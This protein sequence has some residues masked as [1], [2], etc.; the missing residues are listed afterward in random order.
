MQ[1][2]VDMKP[3]FL[4]F[5]GGNYLEGDTID[6]RFDWKKT[7]GPITSRPG[8]Q[9]PW[10]YMSTDGLGLLEFLE[11]T[12]DM[13]AQSVL[14][15]YAGYSLK[16]AHV[17]PGPDLVPFIQDDLDE[18]EYVTGDKS[19]KW[20]DQRIADGHPEPFPLHYVEIG[21]EDWFDKSGSYDARFAQIADAIHEKYP[22]LKL[23]ATTKVKSDK[24]DLID[25]H[26]YRN[27]GQMYDDATHYDKY[28]RD[29]Q[30]VFVGE[31]ATREGAPTTNLNAALGD[32]AWMTGMERNSD[33][34]LIS[35]Y[36]P[37]FVNVNKGG[38]QWPS[39]LIGYDALNSFG[40][41]SY[42][43]QKIFSEN[44]GDT[45]VSIEGADIPSHSWQPAG[46]RGSTTKPPAKDVPSLF[47]VATRNTQT[48]MVYLK[49][50][51][52]VDTAQNVS[53]TLDGAKSVRRDGHAN[54]H[55]FGQFERYE[56]HHGAD[57]DCARVLRT[58]WSCP[59]LRPHLPPVLGDNPANPHA[60]K[61]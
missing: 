37:L 45:I 27:S 14:A 6:Q 43:V 51:N 57:E 28:K 3:S 59:V 8:H 25:E 58:D 36:A 7:V 20:G 56:F 23:I 2:L 10:K 46:R 1:K 53:I 44:L 41:P 60:V 30:K 52:S 47:Y 33:V 21:N 61:I 39:D 22:D 12:S 48:G 11:W 19:T 9:S 4:R 18:I 13:H 17:N 26:Y 31:W 42:Y 24:A 5:P 38:M 32:A 34:V 55:P 16:G 35:C 50:V 15:V 49:F 54:R 29:G 40:S